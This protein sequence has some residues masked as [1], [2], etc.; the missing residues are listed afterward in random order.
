MGDVE[1]REGRVRGC[2]LRRFDHTTLM[3]SISLRQPQ[4][5]RN[6]KKGSMYDIINFAPRT[7]ASQRSP[8]PRLAIVVTIVIATSTPMFYYS[9]YPRRLI[10]LASLILLELESL[11]LLLAQA[12]RLASRSHIHTAAV[13][14]KRDLL[15]PNSSRPI[16]FHARPH[17]VQHHHCDRARGPDIPPV[18]LSLSRFAAVSHHRHRRLLLYGYRLLSLLLS[19]YYLPRTPL[20]IMFARCM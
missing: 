11:P 10:G 1:G 3:H 8:S 9:L 2:L 7:L 6:D 15:A 4:F 20:A 5:H 14:R 17:Y 16:P 13:F 18:A 12:V 19:Y